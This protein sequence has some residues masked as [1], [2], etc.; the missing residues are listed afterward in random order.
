MLKINW[1]YIK[2]IVLLGLV[3]FLYAFSSSKHAK[4]NLIDSEIVFEGESNLFLTHAN[5]SK[6]LIQNKLGVKNTSKETLDLNDLETA[7]KSNQMVKMAEVYVSVNGVL[8]AKI[9]QKKPIARIQENTSYYIDDQGTYMPLSLNYTA[10]VPLVTGKVDKNKL[11]LVFKM[12]KK[13]NEDAFLKK[14]VIEIHQTEENNLVLK[15]RKQAFSVHVGNLNHLDKKINNLKAFY[16]KALKDNTLNN[17][18]HVNLQFTS[19]VVCTKI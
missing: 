16:N 18:A 3:V 8:T 13:V 17:Y 7:L 11:D 5:V 4:R 1:N 6:L 2:M 19:Q 12:A 10:R 14:H 9:T 15:F